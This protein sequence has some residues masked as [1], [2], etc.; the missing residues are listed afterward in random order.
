MRDGGDESGSEPGDAPDAEISREQL[1]QLYGELRR[2]AAQAMRGQGP[3]HTLQPT[4]LVN[5]AFLRFLK[6]WDRVRGFDRNKLRAHLAKSMTRLLVDHSRRRRRLKR[7]GQ[8]RRMTIT[9][10]SAAAASG[11]PVCD[12]VALGEILEKLREDSLPRF[13]VLEL[14]VFGGMKL[15]EIAEVEGCSLAT[16]K[17]RWA[18][19]KARFIEIWKQ[20]DR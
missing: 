16:V 3:N 14:R 15:E 4:A 6:R 5:E 12:A 1:E 8:R 10:T 7:G 17:Q 11:L 9:L 19:V 18:I 2:L 13:R 20:G